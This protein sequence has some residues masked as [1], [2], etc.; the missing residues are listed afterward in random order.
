MPVVHQEYQ[1]PHRFVVGEE[2][3]QTR[4][5]KVVMAVGIEIYDLSVRWG[6]HL[7]ELCFHPTIPNSANPGDPV[8]GPL[9]DQDVVQAVFVEIDDLQMGDGGSAGVLGR[10]ITDALAFE[11]NLRGLRIGW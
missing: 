3:A 10:R 6:R 5:D 4:Y 7:S 2:A 11:A 8:L 9:A 1:N